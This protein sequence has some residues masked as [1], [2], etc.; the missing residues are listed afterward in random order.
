MY[1]RE[2]EVVEEV[3]DGDGKNE[4]VGYIKQKLKVK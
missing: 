2:I 3:D 1:A 4:S